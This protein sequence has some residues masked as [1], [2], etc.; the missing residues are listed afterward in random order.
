MQHHLMRYS[1]VSLCQEKINVDQAFTRMAKLIKDK[2]KD[3]TP[4]TGGQQST[5]DL[6][7]GQG[8]KKKGGCC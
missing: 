1:T 2:R 3:E 8:E 4:A 7:K 5:L 6:G